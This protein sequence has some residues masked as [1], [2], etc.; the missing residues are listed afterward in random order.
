MLNTV[1]V[2]QYEVTRHYGGP[3]EGGWWYDRSKAIEPASILTGIDRKETY[4]QAFHIT[5]ALNRV[6]QAMRKEGCELGRFSVSGGI[7]VV[8]LIEEKFGEQ[9]DMDEPRPH[10]E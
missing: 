10:Y 4:R 8:F 5:R 1:F 7:D 2:S 6:A 3:E 9:D